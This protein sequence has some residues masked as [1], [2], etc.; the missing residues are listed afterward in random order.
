VREREAA[1][2]WLTVVESLHAVDADIADPTEEVYQRAVDTAA[3]MFSCGV[4]RLAIAESGQ[5]IPTAS[6]TEDSLAECDPIPVAAGYAGQTYLSDK[7]VRIDDL[8]DTRS[9]AQSGG[10]DDPVHGE[11]ECG[12]HRALLSVPIGDRGVLQ[13]FATEPAAFTEKDETLAAR[14]GS[15]VLIALDSVET[16]T[17]LREERDRFEEFASIVSH[18]LRNPLQI[19][20]GTLDGV[21]DD[22]DSDHIERGYRALSRMETMIKDLLLLARQDE[23]I[24][25]TEA[26][27]MDDVIKQCWETSEMVDGSLIVEIESS[28]IADPD[29]LTQLLANLFRNAREHGGNDVT[30]TVGALDDGFYVAD[31]GPGIPSAEREAIFQHGYSTAPGG[32]GLGLTIV[33]TIATAHGWTVTVTDSSD[34]GA[35][36][37]FRDVECVR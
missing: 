22:G 13:L 37:E 24:R 9:V 33:E 1:T 18:D 34:G 4:A 26:V 11:N 35:R 25:E 6:S 10:T 27:S 23:G 31:D 12:R 15:H 28:L 20:R 8:T 30:V 5:L 21:S 7:V 16:E 29:R 2:R 36:F 17:Y 32:T 19:L 14:F 3:E